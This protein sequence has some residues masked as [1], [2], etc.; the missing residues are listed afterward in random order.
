MKAHLTICPFL[1]L[2][3]TITGALIGCGTEDATTSENSHELTLPTGVIDDTFVVP[4]NFSTFTDDVGI[5][6]ISYPPDWEVDLSILEEL[7]TVASEIVDSIRSGV[8][9]DRVNFVFIAGVP[10]GLGYHPNIN[11]AIEP[12][13]P[14]VRTTKAIAAAEIIGIKAMTEDFNEV[15]RETVLIDGREAVILEYEATIPEAGQAHNLVMFTLAGETVWA[16]T[17]T[18]LSDI[19][20]YN[21]YEEDFQAIVRS[22]KIHE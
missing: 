6:S 17:C 21:D 19:A 22:L 9:L 4:S 8:S 18:L 3:V 11:I 10:Y 5:F 2:V 14:L 15:N 13:P 20:D 16:V 7:E 1:I 12:R